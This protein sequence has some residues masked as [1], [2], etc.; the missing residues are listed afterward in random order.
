MRPHEQY[1]S[2]D[3]ITAKKRKEPSIGETFQTIYF[4]TPL[5]KN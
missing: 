2:D 4:K 3:C 1:G 5:N